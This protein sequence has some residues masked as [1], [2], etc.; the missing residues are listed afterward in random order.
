MDQKKMY[1][2]IVFE[3]SDGRLI[4]ATV[5]AFCQL[6]DSVEVKRIRVTNPEELPKDYFF[7]SLENNK[8]GAV[9]KNAG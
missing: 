4:S 7:E 8:P 9:R 5:P 1:Q 3:L 2:N 6:G